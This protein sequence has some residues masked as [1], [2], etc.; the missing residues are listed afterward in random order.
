M[1][2]DYFDNSEQRCWEK[3]VDFQE[4]THLFKAITRCKEKNYADA[5]GYTI[6]KLGERRNFNIELK[7]R[8]AALLKSG[9]FSAD[10]FVDPALFIESHKFCDLHF[11]NLLGLEGLYINFLNNNVTVI[12]HIEKITVKPRIEKKKIPSKGYEGFEIG[13]RA[14]LH[15][16]DAAI[17]KDYKLVKRIGEEWKN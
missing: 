17:Y 14:F 11:N 8:N 2:K 4:H 13:Y 3:L 15:I 1:N 6:S 10:T 16:K 7:I 12:Y 9:V 5:T